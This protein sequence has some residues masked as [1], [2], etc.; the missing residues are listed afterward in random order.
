MLGHLATRSRGG[1]IVEGH[2]GDKVLLRKS[3]V[4]SLSREVTLFRAIREDISTTVAITSAWIAMLQTVAAVPTSNSRNT[5]PSCIMGIG[6]ASARPGRRAH[7]AARRRCDRVAARHAR[8]MVRV[9][10]SNTVAGARRW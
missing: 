1:A 4:K 3:A 10:L 2:G 6:F 8:A 9:E 7:Q 5:G